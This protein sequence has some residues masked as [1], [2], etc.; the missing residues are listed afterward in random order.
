MNFFAFTANLIFDYFQWMDFLENTCMQLE[1]LKWDCLQPNLNTQKFWVKILKLWFDWSKWN[2][3]FCIWA[4]LKLIIYRP[5]WRLLQ[6]RNPSCHQ[7]SSIIRR[8]SYATFWPN[9]PA[10]SWKVLEHV[11]NQIIISVLIWGYL[12]WKCLHFRS[13][14]QD[15]S[16]RIYS[17][18]IV[19]IG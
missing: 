17:C 12:S 11:E 14:L 2:P 13:N 8:L 1:Q 3:L 19:L 6:V 4:V 5:L 9:D 18:K 16:R 15:T 7:A 10:K